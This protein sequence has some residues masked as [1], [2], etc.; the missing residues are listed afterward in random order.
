M[1]L[2]SSPSIN[3]ACSSEPFHEKLKT[4]S[5]SSTLS[6]NHSCSPAGV[7]KNSYNMPGEHLTGYSNVN[8]TFLLILFIYISFQPC[9]NNKIFIVTKYL[10]LYFTHTY[11]HIVLEKL[12]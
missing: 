7:I 4:P 8:N 9:N 3:S 10:C 1:Y 11:Q 12:F 2:S 5:L 6:A